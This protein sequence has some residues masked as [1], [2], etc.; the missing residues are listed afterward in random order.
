MRG[1]KYKYKIGEIVNK[2]LKVIKQTTNKWNAK[3][4]KVQSMVHPN[5]PFYMITES[6]LNKGVKCRYSNGRR[7]IYEGNSLWSIESIRKYLVD[8]E[9]S[10]KIPP[11]YRQ[12]IK[13]CCPNCSTEQYCYPGDII[14]DGYSCIICKRGLSYAELFFVAYAITKKVS[15]DREKT[16]NDLK[17]RRFDFYN[18]DIGVV[19]LHGKQHYFNDKSSNWDYDKIVSSDKIKKEYCYSNN[20]KYIEIN[21]SKS[22]FDYLKEQINKCMF[23]PSINEEDVDDILKIMEY[24]KNYPIKEIKKLYQDEMSTPKIA[25]KYNVSQSAIE[26]LLKKYNVKLRGRRKVR[27]KN[28]NKVFNSSVEASRWCGLKNSGSIGLVCKGIR[29]HAGKHP[30]TKE[31]LSW[32]YIEA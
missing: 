11:N 1:K 30:E 5:A 23:L 4:Y 3:S 25:K 19:E 20:I 17:N 8:I 24:N 10:K 21:C 26:T 16:F 9:Q 28:N 31:I 18:K 6:D 27:C 13:T 22:N 2:E 14:R 32:E 29:K 15:F 7:H 12:K